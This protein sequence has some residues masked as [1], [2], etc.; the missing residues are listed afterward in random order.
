MVGLI[1]K[2]LSGDSCCSGTWLEPE[3]AVSPQIT[4]LLSQ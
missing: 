4:K 1:E 3:D 2:L